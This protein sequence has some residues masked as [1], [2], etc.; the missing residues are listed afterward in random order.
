MCIYIYIYIYIYIF[1]YIPHIKSSLFDKKIN[2][3]ISRQ[4]TNYTFNIILELKKYNSILSI[5]PNCY[6]F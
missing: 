5:L 3:K 4:I 2:Y 6:T 1:I